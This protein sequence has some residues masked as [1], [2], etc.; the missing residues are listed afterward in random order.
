MESA[1]A[2]SG[3]DVQRRTLAFAAAAIFGFLTLAPLDAWRAT[4][5]WFDRLSVYLMGFSIARATGAFFGAPLK[6]APRSGAVTRAGLL[7][8]LFASVASFVWVGALLWAVAAP[9]LDESASWSVD[10][11]LALLVTAVAPLWL[12]AVRVERSYSGES[13]R[14]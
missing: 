2:R 5:S 7:A 14:Q 9:A 13:P 11:L 8:A 12:L 10:L 6:R 1:P 3:R 4:P